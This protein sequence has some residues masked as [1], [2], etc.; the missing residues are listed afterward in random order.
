MTV[1]IDDD[2]LALWSAPLPG[3]H[4]GDF[5]A[6][7]S[8]DP[9]EPGKPRA[10]ALVWRVKMFA[11]PA[12]FDPRDQRRWR[13]YTLHAGSDEEVV[14]KVRGAVLMML[15]EWGTVVDL[16]EVIRAPGESTEAIAKRI[17]SM[18]FA[19]ARKATMQEL[20]EYES[21]IAAAEANRRGNK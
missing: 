17:A 20:Q 12:P 13:G 3:P 6:G 18:P 21:Q 11:S 4:P 9:K 16:S 5:L 15:Q 19:H 7:L 2:L 8:R 10:Y 14:G 1:M